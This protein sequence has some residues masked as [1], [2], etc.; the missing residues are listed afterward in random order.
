MHALEARAIHGYPDLV[1][2]ANYL[3]RLVLLHR[4][5]RLNQ[6]SMVRLQLANRLGQIVL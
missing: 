4:L 2:R 1:T 5:N 3:H 6:G